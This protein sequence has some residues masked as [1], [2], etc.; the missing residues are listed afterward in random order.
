MMEPMVKD[1]KVMTA[2]SAANIRQLVVRANNLNVKR[3]DI[4]SLVKENGS[5]I[6]VYYK[7]G[8]T[9]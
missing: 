5:F 3:E 2:I 6:L 4:V 8:G 7:D 1:G 9:N